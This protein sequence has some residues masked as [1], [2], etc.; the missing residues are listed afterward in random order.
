MCI[1]DGP[2]CT[3]RYR[4]PAEI[5]IIEYIASCHYC[6]SSPTV[7]EQII[8]RTLLIYHFIPVIIN[9][10]S[11]NEQFKHI[12]TKLPKDKS[13]IWEVEEVL[14]YV[15][16]CK[17]FVESVIIDSEEKI[18]KS[19]KRINEINEYLEIFGESKIEYK[20]FD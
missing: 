11:T 6:L 10:C 19:E 8:T 20:I 4:P 15:P 12:K 7:A 3:S 16:E 2:V 18:K 5:A 13:N 17:L 1:P 14:P 9:Y